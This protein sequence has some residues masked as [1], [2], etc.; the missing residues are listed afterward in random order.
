MGW[1][2]MVV[3]RLEDIGERAAIRRI[4]TILTKGKN[5]AGIGDDCATIE[6]G[7]NICWSPP[8]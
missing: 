7:K 5:Q 6:M 4:A 1:V 8:I 2:V 3:K